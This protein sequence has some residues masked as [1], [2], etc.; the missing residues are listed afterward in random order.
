MFTRKELQVIR[1]RANEM[2]ESKGANPMWIRA[3]NDLV[4]AAD[5]LDAYIARSTLKHP[6]NWEDKMELKDD[7]RCKTCR[8]LEE[9]EGA[10]GWCY[11]FRD[12]MFDC[13]KWEPITG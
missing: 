13:H 11:M 5:V 12:Q 6:N 2:A 1:F 7:I 3:Y 10:G 4:H 9:N 8:W